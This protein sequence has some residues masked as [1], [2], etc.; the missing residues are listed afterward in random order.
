M[1][2]MRPFGALLPKEEALALILDAAAPLARAED[3]PLAEARGRVSAEDVRAPHDVP[4]YA[5]A[6]M[7]GYAVRAADGSAPRRVTGELFAG[8]RVLPAVDPGGAVRIATGAPVP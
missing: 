4:P 7:D 1:H 2:G 6:T 3:V 5:R 8:A